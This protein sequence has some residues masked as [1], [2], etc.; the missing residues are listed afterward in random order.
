MN[1]LLHVAHVDSDYD[2]F[3]MQVLDGRARA[4]TTVLIDGSTRDRPGTTEEHVTAIAMAT[5]ICM[6]TGE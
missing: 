4:G 5:N 3:W 2:A 1:S 6:A